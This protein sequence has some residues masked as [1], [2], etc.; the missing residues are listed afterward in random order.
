MTDTAKSVEASGAGIWVVAEHIE[1]DVS[2]ASL[3]LLCEA[4]KLSS[5]L[6]PVWAL[7]FGHSVH[8]LAPKL[9][10]YGADRVLVCDAER[11]AGTPSRIISP[12]V[13]ELIRAHRP[14]AVLLPATSFGSELAALVAARV[15]SPLVTNAVR[16]SVDEGGQVLVT[17]PNYGARVHRT[18]VAKA[19]TTQL[20]TIRPGT[21][22]LDRP[23][24]FR[25]YEVIDVPYDEPAQALAAARVLE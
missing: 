20:V 17:K 11:L 6:G 21:I 3:E 13:G 5:K 16:L 1:G 8:E 18:F 25:R 12:H 19:G 9:G 15:S 22:G 7:L 14:R 2:E 24:K 23:D 10:Q 4:R